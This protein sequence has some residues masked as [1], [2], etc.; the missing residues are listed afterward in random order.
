MD[1]LSEVLTLIQTNRMKRVPIILIGTEYWAPFMQ[2]VKEAQT[3]GL[4]SEQ[5]VLL[6]TVTDDLYKAFCVVRDECK[7]Q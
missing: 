3:H 5:D 4:V 6:F 2:W 7:L 1:E